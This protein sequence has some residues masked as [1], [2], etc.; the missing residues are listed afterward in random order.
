MPKKQVSRRENFRSKKTTKTIDLIQF[1]SR[2]AISTSTFIAQVVI[3]SN[4]TNQKESSVQI[5][6]VFDQII[7]EKFVSLIENAEEK[8][9]K[10]KKTQKYLRRFSKF[11][12]INQMNAIKR[13]IKK[14][15]NL[16]HSKKCGDLNLKRL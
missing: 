9:R 6:I 1:E 15:E 3:F 5:T 8:M 7:F 12:K 2:N 13:K 16:F 4:V 14:I 10:I 11:S